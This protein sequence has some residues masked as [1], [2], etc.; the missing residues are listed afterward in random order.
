M[1]I[2]LPLFYDAQYAQM[3]VLLFIQL[4]ELVRMWKIWP[5]VSKAR[6]WLRF[7]LEAA[8]ALFFLVNLIQIPLLNALQTN[9]M[10]QMDS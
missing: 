10:A 1:I 2:C 4:L 5:F 3:G 8:L 9:D 6:N 7:S